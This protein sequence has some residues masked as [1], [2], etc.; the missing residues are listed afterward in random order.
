[1]AA[2]TDLSLVKTGPSWVDAGSVISY[3]L[4]VTNAGPDPALAMVVTDTL[5]PGV[6]YQSASG[7]GW[8]C[9]HLADVVVS[10]TRASLASGTS[11][12]PV[13][14]VVI[15]PVFATD[16]VNAA[17]VASATFDPVAPNNASTAR[18]AVLALDLPPL[19]RTGSDAL[20]SGPVGLLALAMGV[21][22]VVAA[23]RWR[24]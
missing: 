23:R 17:A 11:A 5:P 20:I 9:H 12:P 16:V 3:R 18:T 6:T 13:L 22:L 4:V 19:P 2:A 1:V 15:G 24:D 8:S 7:S 21:V 14:V 10:C